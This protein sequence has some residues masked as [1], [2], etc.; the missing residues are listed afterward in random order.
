M[1]DLWV[2]DPAT[3]RGQLIALAQTRWGW[4]ADEIRP[5][6]E[7]MG[8]GSVID[9]DGE[10]VFADAPLA[11]RSSDRHLRGPRW[12]VEMITIGMASTVLRPSPEESAFLRA[13]ATDRP[14][15]RVAVIAAGAAP[16]LLSW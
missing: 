7:R 14:P 8:W 3:A 9:V 10:P 1:T 2:V 13:T 11:A 5:L 6:A 15:A 4:T 12:V 16:G